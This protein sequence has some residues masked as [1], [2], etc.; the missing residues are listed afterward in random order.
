MTGP[1]REIGKNSFYRDSV[2]FCEP[3]VRV[4]NY[5]QD[6]VFFERLIRANNFYPPLVSGA[7]GKIWQEQQFRRRSSSPGVSGHPLVLPKT[8]CISLVPVLPRYRYFLL[9]NFPWKQ[10][11]PEVESDTKSHSHHSQRKE[12]KRKERKTKRIRFNSEVGPDSD[13][14][15]LPNIGQTCHI[16]TAVCI[17]PFFFCRYGVKV[18]YFIESFMICLQI[19]L[20]HSR[21][22]L[23]GEYGAQLAL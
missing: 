9:S 7:K 10:L 21:G 4:Q 19:A 23:V 2:L 6:P 13:L 20:G 16:I 1:T 14:K 15:S 3:L 22:N 11:T 8:M 5:H 18:D 12:Q 17:K